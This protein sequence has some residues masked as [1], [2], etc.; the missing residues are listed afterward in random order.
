MNMTCEVSNFMTFGKVARVDVASGD[1]KRPYFFSL[2]SESP[3][4]EEFNKVVEQAIAAATGVKVAPVAVSTPVAAPVAAPA[5]VVTPTPVAAPVA[6][7][8]GEKWV[9][10]SPYVKMV[11]DHVKTIT[12]QDPVKGSKLLADLGKITTNWIGSGEIVVINGAL[13]ESALAALATLVDDSI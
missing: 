3:T 5:V 9:K 8:I 10:G 12:G 4:A 13:T 11:V 2:S 1:V 7:P 6:A